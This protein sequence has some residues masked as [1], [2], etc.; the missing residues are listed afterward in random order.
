MSDTKKFP[1]ISL[2]LASG[3]G[4]AAAIGFL[5]GFAWLM[6]KQGMTQDA[7][8]PFVTVAVCLGSC[9]AGTLLTALQKE[10]A[11]LCG[12]AEGTFF[13][14]ILFVLGIL[15]QSEWEAGQFVRAGLVLLMGILGG[16]LGMM[17]TERRRH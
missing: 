8:A 1:I 9:L 4:S 5:A 16:I 12:S 17:L 6:V 14:G 2:L 10:K 7:A 3:F 13:A 11:L 15:N